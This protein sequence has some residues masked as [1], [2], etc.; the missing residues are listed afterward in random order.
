[1]CNLGQG[2]VVFGRKSAKFTSQNSFFPLE[3]RVHVSSAM[4]TRGA[5]GGGNV[6]KTQSF[7]NGQKGWGKGEWCIISTNSASGVQCGSAEPQNPQPVWGTTDISGYNKCT[8]H[9]E[10]RRACI[11][12]SYT[13]E[14]QVKWFLVWWAVAC[15]K[16]L[17]LDSSHLFVRYH[18]T[19]SCSTLYRKLFWPQVP[20][21][22]IATWKYCLAIGYIEGR[23]LIE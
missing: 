6:N 16:W 17:Y 4:L 15:A 22:G 21:L 3:P 23:R 8:C 10:R 18:A 13:N 1:M 19:S 9:M 20:Y 2:L 12:N 11:T 5:W 7:S 14:P